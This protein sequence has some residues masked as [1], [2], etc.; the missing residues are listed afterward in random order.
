MKT[1]YIEAEQVINASPT[2]VW[3][4]LTNPERT[5]AYMFGCTVL[6]DWQVGSPMIWRGQADGV[7]YI[8]GSLVGLE[9]EKK[10]AFTVF[11]PLASYPDVPENYLTVTYTLS[12]VD[13]G[14]HLHVR[15]G[16]YAL[17]AEGAKRYEDTQAQGGWS[18]VLKKIK[19][20]AE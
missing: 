14:T 17:V 3:D 8:K 11:D 13:G 7:D 15:Q 10:L 2:Q 6:C 18:A 5:P 4:L 9:P 1:Q 16:D 19:E 20:L 12:L